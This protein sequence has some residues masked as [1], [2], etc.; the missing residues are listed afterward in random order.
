MLVNPGDIVVGDDDGVVVV[1]L[2]EAAAVLEKARD[3]DR[4]EDE[5]VARIR[6]GATT[7]EVLDLAK[8]LKAGGIEL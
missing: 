7:V 4:M 1:P 8:Y 6:D 2:A 3:R 5:M